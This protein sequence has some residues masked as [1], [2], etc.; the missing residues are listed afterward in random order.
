MFIVSRVDCVQCWD[1]DAIENKL[2]VNYTSRFLKCNASELQK[3]HELEVFIAEQT[4]NS[5]VGY[6]I[7]FSLVR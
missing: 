7:N 6:P 3:E 2:D 1:Y 5:L 4:T